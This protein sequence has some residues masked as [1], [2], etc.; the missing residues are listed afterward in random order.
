MPRCVGLL[1]D[2]NSLATQSL[3]DP[4]YG[5][6]EVFGHADGFDCRCGF[7]GSFLAEAVAKPALVAT[8]GDLLRADS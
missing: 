3:I 2:A 5:V 4:L 8:I 1:A 7:Y 6:T